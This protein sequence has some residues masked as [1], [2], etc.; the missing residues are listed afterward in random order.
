MDATPRL[1]D[2]YYPFAG[3]VYCRP[4]TGAQTVRRTFRKNAPRWIPQSFSK[5][6]S[7]NHALAEPQKCLAKLASLSPDIPRG[8]WFLCLTLRVAK[9]FSFII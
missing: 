8:V 9:G 7:A 4:M 6:R 1:L 5:K 3:F 2:G